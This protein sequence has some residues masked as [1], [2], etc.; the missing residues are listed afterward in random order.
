M[1]HEPYI[2]LKLCF[3][4][5]TVRC[6]HQTSINLSLKSM[7]CCF[8][9]D[10]QI[11]VFKQS[12]HFAVVVVFFF[13]WEK[14]T[15]T[16]KWSPSHTITIRQTLESLF[17]FCLFFLHSTSTKENVLVTWSSVILLISE[18]SAHLT[19]E[20]ESYFCLVSAVFYI[21]RLYLKTVRHSRVGLRDI[22]GFGL[23]C[24]ALHKVFLAYWW[25]VEGRAEK[26][27]GQVGLWVAPGVELANALD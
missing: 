3:F 6:I 20:N 22:R 19:E 26:G 27:G 8:Q 18:K 17:F 1:T 21:G 5:Q 14:E 25:T 10:R 11:M 4:P 2:Y 12:G 7:P 16:K 23:G 15:K 9:T 24:Q 13:K